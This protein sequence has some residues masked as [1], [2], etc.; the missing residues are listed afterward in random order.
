[1]ILAPALRA[2]LALSMI[3]GGTRVRDH[4]HH[5]LG[6]KQRGGHDLHVRVVIGH[7]GD[8]EPKELVMRV[9]GHDGGSADTVELNATSGPQRADGGLQVV[10]IELVQRVAD[11][12]A[13]GVKN[14]TGNPGKG[15]AAL[16]F[17]KIYWA[18]E[19]KS[20]ARFRRSSM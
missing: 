13:M 3:L 17:S 6:G 10:K 9:P 7:T 20:R 4:H 8:A 11:R 19:G 14:L 12:L 1:M 15:V 2:T 5:V 16:T 18:E